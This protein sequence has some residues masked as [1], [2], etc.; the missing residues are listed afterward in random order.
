MAQTVPSSQR[1]W[2]GAVC[3]LPGQFRQTLGTFLLKHSE[4]KQTSRLCQSE[5]GWLANAS[6]VLVLC[7]MTGSMLNHRQDGGSA[8]MLCGEEQGI[9]AFPTSTPGTSVWSVR[10]R[11]ALWANSS[12]CVMAP[13][14]TLQ[15]EGKKVAYPR[16][17]RP[18]HPNGGWEPKGK[19]KT[20]KKLAKVESQSLPW[21]KPKPKPTS[22]RSWWS[23][24]LRTKSCRRYGRMPSEGLNGY[25]MKKMLS[26]K[27]PSGCARL[28]TGSRPRNRSKRSRELRWQS[29][30]SSCK[31][32]LQSSTRPRPPWRTSNSAG[33]GRG[34]GTRPTPSPS[35]RA[36]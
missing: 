35:A 7:L 5:R 36:P 23:R 17:N 20:K 25:V 28:S 8:G 19:N 2:S 29:C 27:R 12:L 3:Q 21:S 6:R 30:G 32:S 26:S 15:Q 33:V 10:H 11:K 9:A 13:Q 31:K 18:Q 16:P 14:T 4:G 1:R 34:R 22:Y 24:I